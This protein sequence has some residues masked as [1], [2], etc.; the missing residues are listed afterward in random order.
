MTYMKN[1]FAFFNKINAKILMTLAMIILVIIQISFTIFLYNPTIISTLFGEG[2]KNLVLPIALIVDLLTILLIGISYNNMIKSLK[3][4]TQSAKKL[5]NGQ[6]NIDD[7]VIW[8]NNDFKVLAATFNQMKSNLLFFIDN[9]KKNVITLLNAIEKVSASLEI[10]EKGNEQVAT[11][12]QNIAQKSQYQ[13]DLVKETVTKNDDIY[14]SIDKISTS[15]KDVEKLALDFNA[16]SIKGIESLRQHEDNI[17]SISD[18]MIS[19]GKFIPTLRENVSQINNVTNFILEIGEQLKLLSL[20]ASIEA[21]R[22]GQAGKGFAVVANEITKLSESTTDQI[23]KINN[24]V[25]N[26]LGS[27]KNVEN[28]IVKSNNDFEKSWQ[29]FADVKNVFNNIE[30]KSLDVINEISSVDT[31]VS[32]INSIAKETAEMSQK[33]CDSSSSV[34]GETEEVSAL[35]EEQLSES[36]MINQTVFSLKSF[37][38][39]IEKLTSPFETGIKPVENNSSKHLRIVIIVFNA[40]H[41]EFWNKISE[42][43]LYAQKELS[44]KNVTVDI[45][46]GPDSYL[47]YIKV[48]RECQRKKYDGICLAAY[49]EKLMPV[50]DEVVDGGIPIMAYNCD[51]QG[52]NKRLASVR[53]NAYESGVIA[54]RAILKAIQGK[55]K[56]IVMYGSNI[57]TDAQIRCK[58]FRDSIVKNNNKIIIEDQLTCDTGE[59]TY[60]KVK[61]LLKGNK[62]IDAIYLVAKYKLFIA[63]A[64]EEL[65]LGGKVKFITYDIDTET[66]K[67]LKKGIITCTIGQDPFG[68]GH[69]SLVHLYN[70]L[71][72]GKKPDQEKTWSRI[73]VYDAENANQILD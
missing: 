41:S 16:T 62:D 73:E 10:S 51:F 60:E 43:A 68:Q 59:E 58:G 53:Q 46:I 64:I 12:A 18:S 72:T 36:Q 37:V 52:P 54:A 6:L 33:V 42:G 57:N 23:V 31:E 50:V 13:L 11:T 30:N 49:S 7:I 70:Y 21:A 48:I 9:T 25:T 14:K 17:K 40:P 5:S 38:D 32:N 26:I 39:K 71:V 15:I 66:L 44:E 4:I 1:L 29:V 55:G 65:G 56:V 35:L 47:D 20:N 61:Q 69:D 63:K 28:I 45:A 27:S 67:Y 19:T 2:F 24:I 3:N 22:S 34:S 8:E